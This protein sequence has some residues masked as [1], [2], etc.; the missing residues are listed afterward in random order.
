MLHPKTPLFLAPTMRRARERKSFDNS[1][2]SLQNSDRS[3][4]THETKLFGYNIV[5][6]SATVDNMLS[7]SVFNFKKISW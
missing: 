7:I 6:P 5:D 2:V 4:V 3:L 1:S